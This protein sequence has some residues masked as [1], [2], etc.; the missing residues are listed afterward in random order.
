[1]AK[2]SK[3]SIAQP[4]DTPSTSPKDRAGLYAKFG[5]DI[6][7]PDS[8]A[9]RRGLSTLGDNNTGGRIDMESAAR[10]LKKGE[11]YAPG[12]GLAVIR[13]ERFATETRSGAGRD[14]TAVNHGYRD[15]NVYG[16]VGSQNQD[17]KSNQANNQPPPPAPVKKPETPY[18]ARAATKAKTLAQGFQRQQGQQGQQ[19]GS[20]PQ[21]QS[22]QQG[23]GPAPASQRDPYYPS[24]QMTPDQLVADMNQ[25][26]DLSGQRA[27]QG[28]QS[29]AESAN[30]RLDAYNAA[31][32]NMDA[33]GGE[34]PKPLSPDEQFKLAR[35]ARDDSYDLF[36]ARSRGPE[37]LLNT[38]FD[39]MLASKSNKPKRKNTA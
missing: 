27:D 3:V 19:G 16:R 30:T 35:R 20:Q 10:K 12:E 17:S 5:V 15:L 26:A 37:G 21:S 29:F 7:N 32:A 23:A 9:S 6:K 25:R 11:S 2:R 8:E 38:F 22:Q 13:T 28:V 1:M 36:G 39:G 18:V 34:A 4:Y 24:G 14:G 31:A 33:R